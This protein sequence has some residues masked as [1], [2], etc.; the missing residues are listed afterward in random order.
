MRQC[1]IPTWD[2]LMA[3]KLLSEQ[4]VRNH[5]LYARVRFTTRSA[6]V[7]NVCSCLVFLPLAKN[8]RTELIAMCTD[9]WRK[10][11]HAPPRLSS[12]SCT[13]LAS[14]C[15]RVCDSDG[16]VR[17]VV[18]LFHETDSIFLGKGHNT[19]ALECFCQECRVISCAVSLG[20]GDP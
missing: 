16:R 2:V 15:I 4:G 14:L 6:S 8:E 17:V 19:H 5:S 10:E 9:T 11:A 7:K 12:L 1:P 13:E 3:K 18:S 20:D